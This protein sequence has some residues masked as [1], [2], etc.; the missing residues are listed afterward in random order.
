M[1]VSAVDDD[2]EIHSGDEHFTAADLFAL[3]DLVADAWS[4][5]SR[6]NWCTRAGTLDWT[7]IHTADHAVDC[8]YAP[9][10][11]LASRKLDA[12]PAVGVDLTLGARATP[13]LL[14]DS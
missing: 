14:V 7:C 5:A 13:A 6:L 4:S 8:V 2:M 1:N 11:F 10:F 3:S 12:Y 9:A